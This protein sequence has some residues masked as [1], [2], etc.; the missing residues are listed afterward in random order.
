VHAVVLQ[1]AEIYLKYKKSRKHYA[2]CYEEM[3]AAGWLHPHCFLLE[4]VL[5]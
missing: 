3:A 5:G 1:M 2:T 4:L